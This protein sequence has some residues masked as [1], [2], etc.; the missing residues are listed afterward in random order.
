MQA[1]AEQTDRRP[2]TLDAEQHT[3]ARA[4]A[5]DAVA[6]TDLHDHYRPMIQRFVQGRVP[7]PDDAEDVVQEVFVL[8][9]RA[10]ARFVWQDAPLGAWLIVIARRQVAQYWR[11]RGRRPTVELDLSQSARG[12]S[13][14]DAAERA[15]D[16]R[17]T[18]AAMGTLPASQREVVQLRLDGLSH[19]EVAARTGL[20]E[21]NV[22]VL[23][24]RA[25]EKLRRVLAPV[26]QLSAT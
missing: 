8:A 11:V 12:E 23:H 16:R 13:P 7:S 2:W 10:L 24:H 25:V 21:S 5:G 22:R 19:R 26:M 18:L 6:F 20:T 14:E 1:T 4:A 17:V 9:H 15:D 3:V